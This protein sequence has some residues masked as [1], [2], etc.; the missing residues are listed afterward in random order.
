MKPFSDESFVFGG[1]IA[2][3][4]EKPVPNDYPKPPKL[5][6][7]RGAAIVMLNGMRTL[8]LTDKYGNAFEFSHNHETK[9]LTTWIDPDTFEF[10]RWARSMDF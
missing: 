3:F 2:S 9:D 1:L 8:V 4:L 5:E 7:D 10:V 6:A